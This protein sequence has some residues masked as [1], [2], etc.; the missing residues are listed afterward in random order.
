MLKDEFQ[1]KTR[2]ALKA[3]DAETRKI[4]GNILAK[5]LEVEKS[6][7]FKGWTPELE[8]DTVR[9]YIKSL[10]KSI[11]AMP[12][13][14]MAQAYEAEIAVL[15]AYLPQ[16]MSLEETLAIAGPYAEKANGKLGPF[17]GQLLKDHKGK[18]DAAL[19]RKVGE[20]LGLK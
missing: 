19:A 13:S 1:A 9:S 5:L 20:S 18:V 3:R 2:E 10:Q 7:G 4:M 16:M 17:M 12:G 8:A 6:E 14:P 15:Q 11:E